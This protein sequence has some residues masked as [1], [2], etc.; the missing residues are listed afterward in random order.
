METISFREKFESNAIPIGSRDGNKL[1]KNQYGII[2]KAYKEAW[3]SNS[4]QFRHAA[5][6]FKGRRVIAA[7]KN[8]IYKTHPNGSGIYRSIHAE[9]GAITKALKREP[10]LEGF[11][12]FVIRINKTGQTRISKPCKDCM[13]LIE[14]LGLIPQWSE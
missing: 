9:V 4:S 10:D 1:S 3:G 8:L 2:R 12:I 11:H 14:K 6:I 13:K 7:A 5:V